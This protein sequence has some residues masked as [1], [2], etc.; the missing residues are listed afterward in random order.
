MKLVRTEDGAFLFGNA[1][2][3][4]HTVDEMA[5][6]AF[7]EGGRFAFADVAFEPDDPYDREHDTDEPTYRVSL[8]G[9]LLDGVR[10]EP[11]GGG[12]WKCEAAANR[13]PF[14]GAAADRERV[15]EQAAR[16]LMGRAFFTA[17]EARPAGGGAKR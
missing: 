2:Q 11:T 13:T 6:T 14:E 8:R 7:K 15:M 9:V 16:F 10:V 4:T 5:G 17:A 12:G 1:Y 3:T